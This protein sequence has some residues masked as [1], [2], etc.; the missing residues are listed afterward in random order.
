MELKKQINGLLSIIEYLGS[1][2]YGKKRYKI[3]LCRCECGNEKI[4]QLHKFN[5]EK[6]R[7]CGCLLI[8]WRKSFRI[9]HKKIT[10]GYTNHE[11]YGTWVGMVSRCYNKNISAYKYYGER[12]IIVCQEWLSE[13][14]NFYDWAIENGYKKGLT[15]DRIDNDGNYNP[16]NCRWATRKQQ[17]NNTRSNKIVELSG[18]KMS[19]SEAC[20]KLGANYKIIHQRVHRDGLSFDDAIKKP[21]I[22]R[23]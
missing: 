23:K 20:D 17:C 13:F 7:S 16:Y 9:N 8:K 10:H 19:M 1:A 22:K 2:L 3:V 15:L 5:S 21:I 4:I 14:I 18:I 6:I 12:G 11:L